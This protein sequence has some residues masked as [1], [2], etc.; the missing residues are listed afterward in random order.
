MCVT[1]V[2]RYN[3]ADLVP[4]LRDYR[5][6][7]V[8]PA[9]VRLSR[10]PVCGWS[11]FDWN[12]IVLFSFLC[13]LC[14]SAPWTLGASYDVTSSCHVIRSRP[15]CCC[16]CCPQTANHT[17]ATSAVTSPQIPMTYALAA[18]RARR[19]P[20]PADATTFWRHFRFCALQPHRLSQTCKCISR[21]ELQ[22]IYRTVSLNNRLVSMAIRLHLMHSQSPYRKTLL[23]SRFKYTVNITAAIAPLSVSTHFVRITFAKATVHTV[24]RQ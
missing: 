10:Y 14:Y 24:W 19:R 22:A 17:R 23:S 3:T 9:T 21:A 20:L 16:W 11:V 18:V 2:L 5:G 13:R 4:L 1:L 12:A 15:C 8:I 7:P 6:V